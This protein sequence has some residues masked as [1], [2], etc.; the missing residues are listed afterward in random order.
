M[1]LLLINPYSS[2]PYPMIPLGLASLAAVARAAGYSVQV[3]DA[4]AEG[5]SSQAAFEK[6]LAGLAA[7]KVV[8]VTVLTPNLAGAKEAAIAAKKI[9]TNALLVIGGAHVSAVLEEALREFSEADLGV[10][11]EGEETIKAIL[12][13]FLVSGERPQKLAGTIWRN[14][15]QIIKATPRETIKDLDIL[16]R[17]ARDL[18]NLDLYQ[19]HPPYGRRKTYFNEIT[20]RGCPFK[21]SYCAKSVFGNSYRALSPVRVVE[22]IKDLV[23]KYQVR[24]IHFYDDDLTLNRNRAVEIMELLIA[25]KLDLIWSCTTRCDL[26]DVELLKLMK[27]AGCWMISFGVESGSDVLRETVNKGVTRKQIE[28]A[29]YDTKRAKIKTTAYFMIGLP[30]ETEETVKE[31]IEFADKLDPHYVNWAVLTVY[32]NSPFYFD[33]QN[34]KYGKGKIKKA[35][36]ASSPFQ[37]SFQ[38]GFEENLTRERMETLA[39]FATRSFYLRPKRIVRILFDLRSLGHL[40]RTIRAS[41]SLLR[42]SMAKT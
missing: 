24:E 29:F 18:F 7:P 12:A 26:V 37:D 33:L 2:N 39:S 38:L 20:S 4:W 32:P 19:P 10:Y 28:Q 27:Q 23:A 11:G 17:P 22:D 25:A 36:S 5:L 3:V 9:F 1:D 13:S 42:W 41:W 34:G 6:R 40:F 35:D 31:T 30:G 16:P 8:G 15:D 14:S 21:C